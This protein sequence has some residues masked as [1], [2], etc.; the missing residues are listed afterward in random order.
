MMK[1][2][3]IVLALASVVL[4]GCSQQQLQ[5]GGELL[6]ISDEQ[7]RELGDETWQRIRAERPASTN[8]AWQQR[9][10]TVGEQLVAANDFGRRDWDFVVLQGEEVNAFALPGGHIAFYEGMMKLAANDAQIAA[11]MG[12]EIGHVSENHSA[13]R[14]GVAQTAGLGLQA[15]AVALQA[16]NVAYANQIA[17][18]LGAGAQYGL[19][20]PYSRGQ[21]SEADDVGLIYMAR[22]GYDPREAV[23]FWQRMKQNSK[24]APPEMLST[25]PAP[26]SRIAALNKRLPEAMAI[27]QKRR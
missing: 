4:A 6:A 5:R 17:G 8:Q 18:V 19:I 10:R 27:Y 3:S 16:G 15:I 14:V 12:H 13:E 23:A 7:A 24:G 2:C 11:V 9:L 20:M 22:A 1:Q 25:H 26:D 21:E